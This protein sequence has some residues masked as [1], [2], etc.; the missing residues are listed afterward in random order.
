M[1]KKPNKSLSPAQRTARKMSN[2]MR[3]MSGQEAYER[4][5][6]PDQRRALEKQRLDQAE[7]VAAFGGDA[8]AAMDARGMNY[9]INRADDVYAVYPDPEDPAYNAAGFNT[10]Y[11]ESPTSTSN[12]DR[13]RTVAASYDPDRSVLTIMFRDST[14]YNYY[15]VDQ[16]TWDNFHSKT[17]KW[18]FIRDVLDSHPRGPANI[19]DLNPK[20]RSTAYV[21]AR[22]LQSA[23]GATP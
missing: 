17:S 19:S 4:G 13:P 6:P 3:P 12:P 22:S 21:L 9:N 5:L 11:Y 15:D 2:A 16:S 23:K 7:A 10:G 20:I 8:A 14:L 18:E 1:N